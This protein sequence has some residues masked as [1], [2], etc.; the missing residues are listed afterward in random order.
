MNVTFC[1]ILEGTLLVTQSVE[2]LPYKPEGRWFYSRWCHRSTKNI[3]WGV[4]AD[5]TYG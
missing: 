2:V 1:N 5:G 3:S 4:K